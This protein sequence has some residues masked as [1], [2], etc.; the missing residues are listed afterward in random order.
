MTDQL[1]YEPTFQTGNV[2]EHCWDCAADD[3]PGGAIQVHNPLTN[4]D[5][6]ICEWCYRL[7]RDRVSSFGQPDVAVPDIEA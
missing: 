4:E 6:V 3:F 7:R 2:G 1:D 5:Y